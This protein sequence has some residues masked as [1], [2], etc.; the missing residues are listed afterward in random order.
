MRT[1]GAAR[2]AALLSTYLPL[3]LAPFLLFAPLLLRGEVLFW[4]TP[5][6]QFVPWWWA[7]WQQIRQGV[8]PL[9]NPLNGMGA[10]LIANY[11]LAFF[12]PPNWLLLGFAALAGPGGIAWG[13]TFL[14]LF[15]IIWACF[16][17][18]FVLRQL[19]LGWTAQMVG[20]LAYGLSGY[21]VGR[22]GFFSMT[23]VA[24]WLP[25]V[26][27][28][29]RQPY[30]PNRRLPLSPGLVVSLALM[31][32]AGHAQ[33]AW[34][35][36]LLSGAWSLWMG[37]RAG[38]F[39]RAFQYGLAFAAAGLLAAA[40]A[41]AQLGP[42]L[43]YLLTSQ[44]SS[45][46]Q[47]TEVMRYS[48]WP[49]RFLTLFAPDFFGNPGQGDYWG[50][51]SYW[52]DHLYLGVLPLS[53]ALTT[54]KL[55]WKRAH[56]GLLL[57]LWGLVLVSFALALGQ[58][59]ALFPFLYRHIP[60]FNM[61]QAPARY[62]I[63][64]A[65]GLALLAGVGVE[66]WRC[67]V[68]KGLY[69]FRL[70]T[71]GAFAVTLGSGLAWLL[72]SNIQLTFIRATALTGAW[73]LGAGLFT[74]LLPLAQRKGRQSVW[75]WGV[76]GWVT[77]DLVLAGWALNPGVHPDFYQNNDQ[78]ALT[79]AADHE[80]NRLYLSTQAEYD[81]KFS[82]FFRFKDY[83]AL[84]DWRGLRTILLPDLNLLDGIS[85]VNNFDP[86]VPGR[87]ARWMA[88]LEGLSFQDQAPW[89]ALM[90]VGTMERID[91]SQPGGVR[92]DSLPDANRFRWY[93]CAQGVSSEEKAWQALEQQM[94]LPAYDP[95]ML[96]LEGKSG[97][98]NA[99]CVP[100]A[101]V[102]LRL[103][104]SRPDSLSLEIDSPS[105]G[106]LFIAD[107]WYPGW[108]ARLD[109]QSVSLYRAN[110]LFRAVA[111]PAG[112]HLLNVNYTS[113][114]FYFGGLFSILGLF[115]LWILIKD[116]SHRGNSSAPR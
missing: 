35:T 104:S 99:P 81:L 43:E 67:P 80:V 4:G 100:V 44:R 36:L 106:W 51:A 46:V 98:N 60:T 54:L 83:T 116:T 63:W 74:L 96:I 82:R 90:D 79:S 61:F 70:A 47:Y 49:W 21:L 108:Q 114:G 71:A 14:A 68:G 17:M 19:R 16:G 42:T 41:A 57:P 8:L 102:A 39:R 93:S 73:G 22:L 109:G 15:H 76:I 28:F 53:L 78:P 113:V 26:I 66:H 13:Y 52:E 50:Y 5:S 37:W 91:V 1:G 64:A 65:F 85:T 48:F 7:A 9:W 34:Y 111:V 84:E 29:A 110:Y 24:A 95:P 88:A 112:K 86:L 30:L 75:R 6:L 101:N 87:Y 12:Y 32:L 89:L 92:F 69:W 115:L 25:W 11:Q 107:T 77:A 56:R 72:V 27:Y 94:K 18:A 40:I 97:V 103:L 20:G 2:T 10:P 59:I 62:L 3:I 55:A 45:S 31:L 58:N 33:L 23:W 38:G 105:E